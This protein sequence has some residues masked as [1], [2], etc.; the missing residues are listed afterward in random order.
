MSKEIYLAVE[1]WE[2]LNENVCQ[3]AD[4]IQELSKHD[5]A[6][7]TLLQSYSTLVEQRFELWQQLRQLGFNSFNQ[8]H[9]A[10]SN[11]KED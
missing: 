3:V 1:E 4:A 8:I 10:F 11:F 9:A 7:A 2:T 5:F 6:T